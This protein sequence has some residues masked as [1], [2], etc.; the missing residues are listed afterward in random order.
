MYKIGDM[1]AHPMHGAGIIEAFEER[2]IDRAVRTYY[3]FRIPINGMTLM[4]PC[5]EG[6][7]CSLRPIINA[8]QA[9]AILAEIPNTRYEPTGNWNRRYRDNLISIKSGDLLQVASVIKGLLIR[10]I[11]KG[12]SSGEREM[13]R[14]AK[15][16]L[17]SE[18]AMAKNAEYD[19]IDARITAMLTKPE[20]GD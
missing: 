9:D 8:E 15:R 16:I 11:Q 4:I 14:L 3:S 17:V 10:D 20:S 6:E 19:E 1:V 18:I 5:D 7:A 2:R 13:L 12:I